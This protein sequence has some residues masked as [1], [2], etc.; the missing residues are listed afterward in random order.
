MKSVDSRGSSSLVFVMK[1]KVWH[2]LSNFQ[3]VV[4]TLLC[5]VTLKVFVWRFLSKLTV[6]FS[7]VAFV[8]AFHP[9]S[10]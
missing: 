5:N 4:C 8:G 1:M 2:F 10:C 6:M 7:S 9:S 3:K